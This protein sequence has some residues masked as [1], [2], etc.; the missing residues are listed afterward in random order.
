MFGLGIKEVLVVF[1]VAL[2]VFGPKKLPEVARS[3]GKMLGSL[4]R[5]LDDI[6]HETNLS[7]FDLESEVPKT[8]SK[9]NTST[10]AVTPKDS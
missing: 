10:S 1:V 8:P 7:A 6:K 5:T 4:R 2:L 3:L 9:T